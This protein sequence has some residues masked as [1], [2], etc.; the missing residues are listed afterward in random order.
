MHV[1]K[2]TYADL[3][4]RNRFVSLPPASS[5]LDVAVLLSQKDVHRVPIVDNGR[6]INI[7]SQSRVIEFLDA[8]MKQIREDS[9]VVT[10]E[11]AHLATSPVLTIDEHESA[12]NTFALMDKHHKSGIAVVDS[13]GHLIG[14][15]SG[16]D[17]K[18]CCSSYACALSCAGVDFYC[19]CS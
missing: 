8:H 1:T 6:I 18:V 7:I 3:A 14:N 5:L 2:L 19:S 13:T 12:Y 17:L 11:S 16:S 10:V 9:S 4:R 15:T